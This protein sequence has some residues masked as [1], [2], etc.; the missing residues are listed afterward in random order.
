TTIGILPGDDIHTANAYV[1]IPVATGLGEARNVIIIKSAAAV[2][3][4]SGEYGTL[5]EIAFALKAG[6]TVIGL[7]TWELSRKGKNLEAIKGTGSAAD[8]V[9]KALQAATTWDKGR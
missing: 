4:I 6:K 5:S 8:A 7:G 3:A 9:A 2:I 1:S